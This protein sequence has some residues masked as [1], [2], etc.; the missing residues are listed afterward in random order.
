VSQW[1]IDSF[2]AQAEPMADRAFRLFSIPDGDLVREICLPPAGSGGP[3]DFGADG[4]HSAIRTAVVGEQRKAIPTG[5]FA[6][7]MLIPVE[8]LKDLKL[9]DKM[10]D[11]TDPSTTMVVGHDK[12]VI[13]GPGRG[14]KMFGI[15]AL[16]PDEKMV[17]ESSTKSWVEKGSQEK[18]MESY[19]DFPDW[20]KGI[21][22]QASDI[23]L[24]QLRD[25]DPLDTWVRGRTILIG[26][27][28][29]A[30][31]PTQGQ[32]ASQAIEDAEAL[33]AFFRDVTSAPSEDDVSK[34]LRDVFTARYERASLIQK[35]SREQAKPAT[36]AQKNKVKLDPAQ[37]MKY[38]CDYHGAV[39]W[40]AKH[41]SQSA[42]NP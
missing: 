22:A 12:R 36:Y 21:F 15:V 39:D 17:E 11:K 29:H 33:Q 1:G 5:I 3:M 16:V 10:L 42:S 27:A 41:T 25:I 30:M 23:A 24:W 13:M 19:A 40:L 6:Y 35:Y 2:L 26:D 34:R 18:L 32:G 20:L 38:N 7:R 4:I 9:P 8:D 37:F 28:A 31:L 14:G